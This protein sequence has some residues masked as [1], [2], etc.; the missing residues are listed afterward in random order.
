[1]TKNNRTIEIK[2]KNWEMVGRDGEYLLTLQDKA[3]L[4]V[5]RDGLITVLDFVFISNHYR[6]SG[7][8]G[9]IREDVDNTGTVEVLD[10]GDRIRSFW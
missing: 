1:M 2:R 10:N 4:D 5:N 9:W 3:D 7:G 6:G 8:S